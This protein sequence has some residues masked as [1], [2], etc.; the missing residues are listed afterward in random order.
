MYA[1]D[2]FKEAAKLPMRTTKKDGFKEAGHEINFKPA[3]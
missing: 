1:G 3:K 2:P